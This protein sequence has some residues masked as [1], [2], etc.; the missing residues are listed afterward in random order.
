M[1][2]IASAGLGSIFRWPARRHAGLAFPL[3][4]VASAVVH[5]VSGFLF[6][7][8]YPDPTPPERPVVSLQLALPGTPL[9]N[10]LA[11]TQPPDTEALARLLL[12]TATRYRPGFE[13]RAAELRELPISPPPPALLSHREPG[14][15][16]MAPGTVAVPPTPRG[17]EPA[18]VPS[19]FV[20]FSQAL[21]AR[22]PEKP[23]PAPPTPDIGPRLPPTTFLIAV[24]TDGSVL[25]CFR[26]ET[27]GDETV[28]HA[29]RAWVR[30]HRFA[31][32]NDL[33]WGMAR[34]VW[35]QP[36]P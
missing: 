1:K 20:F 27:S 36:P 35:V 2:L 3:L 6:D 9:G 15:V 32:T 24:G 10:L 26:Q 25:H 18:V 33:T 28:D 17:S 29:A 16:R 21:Q 11:P 4:L 7:I 19:G 31:P 14:A 34:C 12:A 8:Q 22:S 13:T 5:L 30:A 23:N